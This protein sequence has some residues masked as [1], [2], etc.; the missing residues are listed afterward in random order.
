[1][2]TGG[3]ASTISTSAATGGSV[4]ESATAPAGVDAGAYNKSG[5]SG[6]RHDGRSNRGVSLG[7]LPHGNS[8]RVGPR[9]RAP[10]AEA[11]QPA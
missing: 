8:C 5:G 11:N 10:C 9:W 7:G 2:T 4:G 1:M 3:G 6:P